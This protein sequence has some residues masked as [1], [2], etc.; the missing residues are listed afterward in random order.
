MK[1]KAKEL[2]ESYIKQIKEQYNWEP[3]KQK[4]EVRIKI[5]WFWQEVD[6]DNVHKLSMDAWNWLLR[7][8]DKQIIEA[9]IIKMWKDNN[10]PRLELFIVPFI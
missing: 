2:K 10:N 3:I 1:P 6:R 7:D 9:T 8:D 4:I 5:R